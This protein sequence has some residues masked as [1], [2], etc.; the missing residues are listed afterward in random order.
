MAVITSIMVACARARVN[1]RPS[2][3]VCREYPGFDRGG[4]EKKEREKKKGITLAL[5][6]R[7]EIV[8]VNPLDENFIANR[9]CPTPFPPF[10]TTSP[11][12]IRMLM[13]F[14][15][16][17][18]PLLLPNIRVIALIIEQFVTSKNHRSHCVRNCNFRILKGAI[19]LVDEFLM[20][21]S[22][23]PFFEVDNRK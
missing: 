12:S 19:W 22:R 11:R 4:G 15:K 13:N 16:Q 14:N 1:T 7:N 8:T 17:L 21:N 18:D 23:L 2:K 3:N 5:K 9:Y 10:S 6:T 20:K